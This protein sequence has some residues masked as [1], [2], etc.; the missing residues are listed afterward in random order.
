MSV[1][2][3]LMW[4]GGKGV[5]SGL[6]S[7]LMKSVLKLVIVVLLCGKFITRQRKWMREKEGGV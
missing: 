2:D 1:V 4:T 3:S 5:Y 7:E 6:H